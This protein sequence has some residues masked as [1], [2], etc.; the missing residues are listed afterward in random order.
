MNHRRQSM[1]RVGVALV[2]SA[3]L[4]SVTSATISGTPAAAARS[5]APQQFT[6]A[7]AGTAQP[8]TVPLITGDSVRLSAA[9]KPTA[10]GGRV[11]ATAQPR[12]GGPTI[13]ITAT[14][15]AGGVQ[16]I[17][18]LPADVARL[19]AA[20]DPGL[21]DV[22]WL[23]DHGYAA[24][25]ARLPVVVQYASTANPNTNFPGATIA[26]TNAD[27]TAELAL[28]LGQAASFWSAV[29][30]GGRLGSGIARVWLK[31]HILG[32]ATSPAYTATYPVTVTVHLAADKDHQ[33][34]ACNAVRT[35]M[36]VMGV[37][38]MGITGPAAGQAFTA[39]LLGCADIDP[40]TTYGLQANVPSGTYWISGWVSFY[41]D[42]YDQ[43]VL[44]EKPEVTVAGATDVA[45]EVAQARPISVQTPR[46]S[47][48]YN[49]M[50]Q[51]ARTLP[52][53]RYAS[54]LMFSSYGNHQ[55]WVTPSDR[56]STGQ[57]RLEL[58]WVG[59]V[60]PVTMAI[61][62]K[63]GQALH[64][65]YPSYATF[66][67]YP[68]YRL[69]TRGT[70][71]VVAAGEGTEADFAKVNARGKLVLLTVANST[72]LQCFGGSL[73]AVMDWQLQNAI[74]A[75]AVGVLMDPETPSA[76]PGE[77]CA[78]PLRG[79]WIIGQ[80]PT[81]PMPFVSVT[82][83]D[84]AALRARLAKGAVSVAYT[85][86]GTA[87]EIYDLKF[88]EQGEIPADQRLTVRSADLTP[89]KAVYR[90]D[91]AQDVLDSRVTSAFQPNEF[92]TGGVAE[93][94]AA[95][96]TRTEYTGPISPELVH[97]DELQSPGMYQSS[98][99]VYADT[100]RRTQEWA[101]R[102][103]VPGSPAEVPDVLAAQPGSW[104]TT[105][106]PVQ[107]CSYCRQG[108][109]FYPIGY[110]ESDRSLSSG[111][112]GYDADSAHLYRN[113][114]EVPQG[115]VAGLVAYTLP[116][117]SSAYRLA[118]DYRLSSYGE[119]HTQ[120]DF[121]SAAPAADRPGAGS[122]CIG[123][124]VSESTDPCAADPLVFVAY[125][126][127]DTPARGFTVEAYHQDPQAP[128]ITG[129]QVWTSTD[130]GAH[131][132]S[133][134]VRSTQGGYAVTPHVTGTGALSVRVVAVDAAGNR[135]DQTVL[136]A[137]RLS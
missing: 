52:D 108:N 83:S 53:G 92:L 107:L 39:N 29:A 62:G 76:T 68:M 38:L 55:Y 15:S 20:V 113:G 73:G 132:T 103:F 133:A 63:G 134:T 122:I 94:F 30:P 46:P 71:G 69:A 24:K 9:G 86:G 45:F 82:P 37:N 97:R 67:G 10:A 117:E 125:H 23:A 85:D 36:C 121:T 5:G 22:T 95:P 19:G 81:P 104:G 106:N 70:A 50:L 66:P 42:A 101:A 123:T 120:W 116:S 100:N 112:Y 114:V 78:L 34:F 79:D 13:K 26:K 21:F 90:T 33:V 27:H 75:G 137:V 87:T 124:L 28:D 135:V 60:T 111:L 25:D 17:S 35:T 44:L 88:Y 74:R 7:Q 48:T 43:N 110:M 31:D 47:S 6:A 131:W 77:F 64:A 16:R 84:A 3:M 128:R 99:R 40:C 61:A 14:G 115:S 57:F 18:A 98:L 49:A 8:V 118:T 12:P 102:P 72:G 1:R 59:G 41:H 130:D 129:V 136:Q 119:V 65:M 127:G 89:T 56:V 32:Y 2:A 93:P 126:F 4:A 51:D 91:T 105:L 109:T 11:T 80:D 58:G 96:T 54:D